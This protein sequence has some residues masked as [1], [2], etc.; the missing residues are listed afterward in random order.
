MLKVE[1]KKQKE[2]SQTPEPHFC[3]DC[4]HFNEDYEW[5]EDVG[6]EILVYSCDKNV[7]KSDVNAVLE[8]EFFEKAVFTKYKEQDTKCDSCSYLKD[9]N[10]TVDITT[11][12]DTRRHFVPGPYGQCHMD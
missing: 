2:Q 7:K 4:K 1:S 6:D 3:N 8:C 12:Y 5:D 9:C 10:K 11:V